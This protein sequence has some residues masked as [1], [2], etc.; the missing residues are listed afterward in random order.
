[1]QEEKLEKREEGDTGTPTTG[2]NTSI[3]P[4]ETMSA[5]QSS[6]TTASALWLKQITK[7]CNEHSEAMQAAQLR[8]T[9]EK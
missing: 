5:V 1:M 8:Y 4:G 6:I 9:K 3:L 7:V 2:I